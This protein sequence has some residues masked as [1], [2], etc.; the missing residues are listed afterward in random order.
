VLVLCTGQEVRVALVGRDG[1]RRSW[2]LLSKTPVAEVQLAQPL[3]NRLVVV[4]R[5]Y[6]DSASEFTVA[7]LDRSGIVQ[8][9]AVPAADWA[10]TAPVSRFRLAGK[11]LF[12]LGSTPDGAFVDRYDLGG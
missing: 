10:E 4:F 1:V 11:S 9:F 12:Q 2:R 6:T 3:G 5:T 8:Q 7:V